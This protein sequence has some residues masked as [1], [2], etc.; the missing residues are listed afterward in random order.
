MVFNRLMAS[1]VAAKKEQ[2]KGAIMYTCL[3]LL[4]LVM[5]NELIVFLIP[6]PTIN[7]QPSTAFLLQNQIFN[8][9]QAEK[10]KDGWAWSSTHQTD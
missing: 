6:K 4:L 8:P 7:L 10:L 2:A 3:L 9:T 5:I 1:L